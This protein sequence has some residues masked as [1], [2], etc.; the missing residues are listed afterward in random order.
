MVGEEKTKY[1]DTYIIYIYMPLKIQVEKGLL[2]AALLQC[3]VL[4]VGWV[5]SVI[6]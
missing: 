2:T 4:Q 5:E 6:S 1:I 3:L